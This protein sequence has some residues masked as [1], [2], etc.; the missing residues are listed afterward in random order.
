MEE[1]FIKAIQGRAVLVFF[2]FNDLS[3]KEKT[4]VMDKIRSHTAFLIYC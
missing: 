3:L 1:L 2:F 4:L